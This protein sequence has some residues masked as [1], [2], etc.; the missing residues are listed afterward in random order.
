MI[1]Y[2]STAKGRLS[3]FGSNLFLGAILFFL[4]TDYALAIPVNTDFDLVKERVVAE[5]LTSEVNAEAIEELLISQN[6]DGTWPGINYQDVSRTGFEHYFHTGNMVTLAKAYRQPNSKYK[7]SPKV[8]QA[9]TDALAHWVENDY[10]CDNWWHNQIGTPNNLVAVMLLLGDE[11]PE[12]LVKAAQP[13]IGR[14]HLNASG[15]RPSGDRIKIAGI[16]AKNLL[17][18]G[19]KEKFEAVLKVIEGEIKFST[20]SRGLQRDFSFHHRVDRVN[21]TSSY[22]LGYADA[23]V[24][25]LVYTADTRYAFSSDKVAILV[26]YYLDGISKNLAFGKYLEAGAKNRSIARPG[27]LHGLDAKTPRKLLQATDYRKVD[28]EEI[29]KI[30]EEGIYKVT[31]SYAKYFWQTEFFT[32]QR[33]DYFT[34]VR[35]FSTR[36]DNMEV[37]YN[38][39]GLKNHHRGDGTNHLSITGKEYF[40]IF[41]VMDFQKIPGTTI[42]QKERLPDPD[43]IQKPGY[44]DFV[45]AVTDDLYGSVAFDFISPHDP[46]KAKKSWF[47]FDKEY[48]CL[49]AGINAKGK[50]AVFTTLNHL[51]LQGEVYAK[52][53]QETKILERGK[54]EFKDLDWIYHDRVGYFMLAPQ[55]VE[56]SFGE[57]TGNWTT[58]NQQTRAPQEDVTKDVFSLWVNHGNNVRQASYAYLILPNAGLE[59]TKA[60]QFND[61]IEILSNTPALQAVR[62]KQL[63]QVQANFYKAGKLDLGD[64]LELTMDGPGLVLLHLDDQNIVKMAVSDPSR[65]LDK[66]HFQLN[67]KLNLKGNKQQVEWDAEHWIS[68]VTVQLPEGEFA[69]SSVILG[70]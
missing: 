27:A 42:L 55:E 49:G 58:I 37:P 34:S 69:G 45:G 61:Q 7:G 48:V 57:V 38:S 11:L 26:D 63:L 43:Q 56:L 9:V 25:W 36:N 64:G 68:K 23:F 24:E 35:M 46:L 40:D 29:V 52:V 8:K 70:D 33:P 16:L 65:K 5:Y 17:F 51:L 19:E 39:E 20:G 28:L 3:S 32:F 30:R 21:N 62:H 2:N 44:T 53:G 12:E 41:P 13:I 54:H 22:G 67:S 31:L 1:T 14:A 10:F 47:F 60:Y 6:P 4:L 59:E 18:L 50:Q 15:A 66:M